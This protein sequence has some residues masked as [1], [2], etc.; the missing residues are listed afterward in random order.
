MSSDELIVVGRHNVENVLAALTLGKQAGLSVQE[1][2]QVV[3]SFTGLPH[4]LEW[5][6]NLNGVD[7][8]NNSKSTNA[9]STITAIEALSDRYKSIVLIAGGIAKKED[10][11]K[12]FQLI[13]EKIDAVILIGESGTLFSQ[14][15]NGCPVSIVESM[16]QAVI[17]SKAIAKEGAILL[18][19]LIHI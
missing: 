2:I 5:V 17:S 13:S 9:I 7:Y 12:L 19:S 8:F 14:Q 4:R 10:Y 15:I 16:K 6:T 18:L 3:K 1:M 11:S